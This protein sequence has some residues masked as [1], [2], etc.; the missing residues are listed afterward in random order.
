MHGNGVNFHG[1]RENFRVPKIIDNNA[2]HNNKMYVM[3]KLEPGI[4]GK[5]PPVTEPQFT[6]GNR[7]RLWLIIAIRKSPDARNNRHKPNQ[8]VSGAIII[9]NGL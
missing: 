5:S 9:T 8:T 2:F 7:F 1:G 4:G 6:M 3:L